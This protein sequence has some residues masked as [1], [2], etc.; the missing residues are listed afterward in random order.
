[1]RYIMRFAIAGIA[2][3]LA[4]VSGCGLPTGDRQTESSG[5]RAAANWIAAAPLSTVVYVGNLPVSATDEELSAL[6]STYGVVDGVDISMDP[7][8]GVPRGFALVKMNEPDGATAA[9][10]ALDGSDYEGRR[11]RVF[12]VRTNTIA[13]DK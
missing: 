4:L 1:M 12:F 3:T 6:L 9:V 13:K 11:L 2:L 8:T 10:E 7:D 5:Q